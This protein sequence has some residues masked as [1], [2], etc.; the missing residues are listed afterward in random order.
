MV[1]QPVLSVLEQDLWNFRRRDG[2]E[3]RIMLEAYLVENVPPQETL[4]SIA[5][6]FYNPGQEKGCHLLKS[7]GHE[8]RVVI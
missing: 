7:L 8:S 3:W 2:H 1:Q 6:R 4:H 5:T